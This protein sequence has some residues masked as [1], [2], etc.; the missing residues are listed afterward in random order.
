VSA[1]FEACYH[2]RSNVAELVLMAALRVD[3]LVLTSTPQG[4]LAATRVLVNQHAS[5]EMVAN[6]LKLTTAQGTSIS[7]TPD[8]AI[9]V[10]G[11]L[12]AAAE[13][14]VGAV[15][16]SSDGTSMTIGRIESG[17]APVINPV[18]ESGTILAS[19]VGEPVLAASHPYWIAQLVLESPTARTVVNAALYAVGDVP[20]IAA[21]FTALLI[22]STVI[23]GIIGLT[24]E[25]QRSPSKVLA[26]FLTSPSVMAPYRTAP[27]L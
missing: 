21:G 25:V 7:L 13:A 15:L 3:D 17:A 5:E 19:D 12:V 9:I 23:L 24:R 27:Y 4:T 10:D 8:H 16:T 11:M 18:T 6:V 1:S 20:S 14:I 22:K 26:S 2:G